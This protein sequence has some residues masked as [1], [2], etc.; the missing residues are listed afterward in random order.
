MQLSTSRLCKVIYITS[1][2]KFSLNLFYTYL[3]N[4]VFVKKKNL[5]Q[6]SK[7][8]FDV[9]VI[10]MYKLYNNEIEHYFET[11]YKFNLNNVNV[12]LHSC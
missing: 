1:F 3:S 10:V 8:E 11:E 9:P 4:T 12:E 5:L 2:S 6:T 7:E